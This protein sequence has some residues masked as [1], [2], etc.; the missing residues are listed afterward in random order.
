M[1]RLRMSDTAVSDM[2][3]VFTAWRAEFAGERVSADEVIEKAEAHDF[4]AATNAGPL[5]PPIQ[6]KRFTNPQLRNAL[7]AVAS[8][9][10]RLDPSRL[11]YWLR[12]VKER[13]VSLTEPNELRALVADGEKHRGVVA[14]KLAQTAEG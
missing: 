3:A 1:D 8:K 2:I 5:F 9:N 7:M 14:W 13:V 10:G 12:R 6:E 11:K 4:V